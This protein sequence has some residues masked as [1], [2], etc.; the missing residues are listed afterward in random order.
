[1]KQMRYLLTLIT[2]FDFLKMVNLNTLFIYFLIYLFIYLSLLYCFGVLPF[3]SIVVLLLCCTAMMISDLADYSLKL[4][5]NREKFGRFGCRRLSNTWQ[6]WL[7]MY[8]FHF[9]NAGF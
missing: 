4:G 6:H 9:V 2:I 3:S 8:L 5:R 7:A 1:M